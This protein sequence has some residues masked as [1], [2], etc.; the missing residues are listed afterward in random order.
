MAYEALSPWKQIVWLAHSFW[1]V[2]AHSALFR[3]ALW[4]CVFSYLMFNSKPQSCTVACCSSPSRGRRKAI[5]WPSFDPFVVRNSCHVCRIKSPFFLHSP[6]TQRASR[7]GFE[8]SGLILVEACSWA[9]PSWQTRLIFFFFFFF[10]KAANH[11]K[12]WKQNARNTQYLFSLWRIAI[13]NGNVWLPVCIFCH[14]WSECFWGAWLPSVSFF[15]PL[16]GFQLMEANRLCEKFSI[17]FLKKW[18]G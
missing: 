15:F 11:F 7:K 9:D 10:F 5:P 16:H 4:C 2:W 12:T 8:I 18:E 13:R 14:N 3:S 17:F 1:S 6:G